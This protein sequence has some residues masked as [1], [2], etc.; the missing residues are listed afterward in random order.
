[1]MLLLLLAAPFSLG[2]G[3]L[4]ILAGSGVTQPTQ[5]RDGSTAP[6]QYART[7]SHQWILD[8]LMRRM[9]LGRSTRV[10]KRPPRVDGPASTGAPP[11]PTATTKSH[12]TWTPTFAGTLTMSLT[13]PGA[14]PRTPTRDG[15]TVRSPPA[16]SQRSQ[17]NL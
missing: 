6:H 3:T 13:A 1:M 4:T 15:S 12:Q 11:P 7:Q 17:R 14:T 5:T 16:L 9:Y 8:A 10:E 2:E